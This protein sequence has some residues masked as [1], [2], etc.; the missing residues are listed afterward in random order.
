MLDTLLAAGRYDVRRVTIITRRAG[1]EDANRNRQPLH[2]ERK[3]KK[4]SENENTHDHE[5]DTSYYVVHATIT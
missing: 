3:Q 2:G 5:R 1:H 4:L